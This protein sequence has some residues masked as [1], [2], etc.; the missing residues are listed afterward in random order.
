MKGKALGRAME[1]KD[2]IRISGDVPLI[3]DVTELVTPEL[4]EKIL[5]RNKNNRPINWRK[6]EEYARL[7]TEGKWKLH[8]QGIVIDADG[9]LLTGQKRLWAI[10]YSGTSVLMRISRGCPSNTASLLDRGTPQSARDLATRTTERKHSPIESSIGRVI[11]VL[12]G[13][14]RP[15]PDDIAKVIIEK[16]EILEVLVKEVKGTRKTKTILMILGAICFL[17]RDVHEIQKLSREVENLAN[18]LDLML[19]PAISEHC[20]GKGAAFT[21]AVNHA[22]TCVGNKITHR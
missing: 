20:W 13:N 21:L 8:S 1:T 22:L 15:S 4:A 3:T 10:I 2:V 6:V 14:L 12:E 16:S 17:T 9:N 18:D 5:K 7:M 11:C 19:A